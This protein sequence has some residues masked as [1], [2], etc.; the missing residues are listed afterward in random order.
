MRTQEV[1]QALHHLI[2][3]IEDE[4]LLTIYLQ[5]LE[6]ELNKGSTKGFFDT[7]EEE[8]IVRA[9]ASLKS[10]EADRTRTIADFQKEVEAWMKEK[11]IK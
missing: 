7:K 2:D 8:M 6:R 1:K 9:K 10:I 11:T 5:L 3:K 4:N